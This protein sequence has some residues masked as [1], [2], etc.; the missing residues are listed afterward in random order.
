MS[1]TAK[2]TKLTDLETRVLDLLKSRGRLEGGSVSTEKRKALNR[3]V[4][5]G[6]A[7]Q[8]GRFP[9]VWVSKAESAALTES[10]INQ[11]ITRSI[12]VL[13]DGETWMGTGDIA[14]LA[15]GDHEAVESGELNDADDVE[16]HAVKVSADTMLDAILTHWDELPAAMRETL[17][18]DLPAKIRAQLAK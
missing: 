16:T 17:G 12:V 8:K 11:A 3:L 14:I 1:T 7:V 15:S 10:E 18:N 13:S 9:T 2:P 6:Y 4:A 5:K